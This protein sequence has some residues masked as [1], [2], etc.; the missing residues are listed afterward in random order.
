MPVL[1]YIYIF[2]IL[3][4]FLSSLN[5]FRLG[6][7]VH[8]RV[9]AVLLGLTFFVEVTAA[10]LA[11]GLDRANNW[12]YNSFTLVEF[13]IYGYFFRS[14]LPGQTTKRLVTGFLVMFPL[15]WGITVFYL[16][17]FTAWNS[18]VIIVGSFFCVLFCLLYYYRI[19]TAHEILNLRHLPE[20]WIATGMLI[21][22]MAAL[23]YFGSLNFL[24]QYHLKA[25]NNLLTVLQCL[26]T[27]MYILFTYG[28]LCRIRNT[29]KS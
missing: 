11:W 25:A 22:Y 3:V 20:F 5:S 7:S 10:I 28:F 15:F 14:L 16:F 19:L 26:D 9:F 18:Y 4:A 6:F 13:W 24:I 2:S 21:F 29:K 1:T 23:P 27:L 8:L 17:G 12:V